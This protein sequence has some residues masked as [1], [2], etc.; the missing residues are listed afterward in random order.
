M[1]V[2]RSDSKT[3]AHLNIMILAYLWLLRV[4]GVL[5]VCEIGLRGAR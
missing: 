5:R 4:E 2:Q 3:I 1:M